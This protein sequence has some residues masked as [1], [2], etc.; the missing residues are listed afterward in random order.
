MAQQLSTKIPELINYFNVY[1]KGNILAGVSGKIALPKLQPITAEVGGADILGTYKT[2]IPG[3]FESIEM[4]IPFQVLSNDMFDL[5]NTADLSELTLRTSMQTR[6]RASA[7]LDNM[8][9]SIRVRGTLLEFDPG[10]IE[11][12]KPM[13]AKVVL[14]VLYYK[15]VMDNRTRIELD[16]LNKKYDVDGRDM[17]VKIRNLC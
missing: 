6:D 12:G 8:D 14:G 3:W 11:I 2:Q 16:K 15:L 7:E 10:T 4:E 5:V 1:L 17:L 9:M 13:E